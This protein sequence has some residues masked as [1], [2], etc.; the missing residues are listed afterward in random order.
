MILPYLVRLAIL[1]LACFFL[2]HMAFATG[3]NLLAPWV[4]GVAKRGKASSAPRLLLAARLFPSAAAVLVVA[5]V[6]VPSYLWLEPGAT[7]EKVGLGCLAVAL[8][9][10]VSWGISAGRGMRAIV[11]S[12]QYERH[13]RRLGRE[14]TLAGETTRVCVIDGATGLF[15]LAG[16]LRPKLVVS[17]EVLQNLSA[18][19]LD[20]ALRHER[21]HQT[22]RDN[23]KRL[24]L[25]LAPDIFPFGTWGKMSSCA[26]VVNPRKFAPIANRRAG[27]QP[28]PLLAGLESL[29]RGWA[30]F[31]EWSADD[32]AVD[33]DSHRAVSLAGALV[34]VARMGAATQASPLMT[35]LVADD[36]DLEARVDRLLGATPGS[37]NSGQCGSRLVAA[38][39]LVAGF[40]VVAL[41]GTP[42]LQA[43][44][45]VLEHL[46]R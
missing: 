36:R 3:M 28:V 6:C 5:G 38:I 13:C 19:E 37:D 45:Q 22:S 26:R 2:L 18:G 24:L 44:H 25:L 15:A 41:N 33:G 23:L 16:I 10:V 11:L 17:R 39:I 46:I 35:S 42:T 40:F 8:L 43:A 1:S 30:Q 4:L 21:A 29:E 20:A 27:S 14:T 7:V 32:R 34:R 9:S 31:T 12:L